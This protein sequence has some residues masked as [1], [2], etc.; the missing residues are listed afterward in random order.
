MVLGELLKFARA[1]AIDAAVSDVRDAHA[2]VR[3]PDRDN[4]GTHAPIS[5][6][7][8]RGAINDRIRQSN[9]ARQTVRCARNS[10]NVFAGEWQ[11]WIRFGGAAVLQNRVHSEA[12]GHFARIQ[13]AHAV[14]E[15]KEI[16]FRRGAVAVLVILAD[17]TG[18]AARP[19]FHLRR[20]ECLRSVHASSDSSARYRWDSS[21]RGHLGNP[22]SSANPWRSRRAPGRTVRSEPRRTHPWARAAARPPPSIQGPQ[23]F[24][25][26]FGL[27]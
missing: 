10:V 4:R 27:V 24:W 18:V 14:G 20:H 15:H 26:C 9:R 21:P 19:N 25:P 8:L 23:F 1:Q 12:A 3:E 2:L 22:G 6:G 13:S 16:Q 11:R 7:L 5:R 17:A